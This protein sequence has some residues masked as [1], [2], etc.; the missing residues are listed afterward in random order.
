MSYTGHEVI[1]SCGCVCDVIQA[2]TTVFEHL[3]PLPFPQIGDPLTNVGVTSG[4]GAS[5]VPLSQSHVVVL[6]FVGGN[7][8][9]CTAHIIRVATQ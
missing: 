3:R 1:C 2:P 7:I 9:L 8:A 5:A 4:R 6:A